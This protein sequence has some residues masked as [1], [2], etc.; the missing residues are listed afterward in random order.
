MLAGSDFSKA[1]ATFYGPLTDRH[2]SPSAAP[3]LAVIVSHL[4]NLS[5]QPSSL[6]TYKR[7]WKLFYDFFHTSFPG[8]KVI[9]PIS[10]PYLELFILFVRSYYAAST[11][12]TYISAI[13]YSHK[14]FSLLGPTK[15]FFIVQM[16]KGYGKLG[17]CIDGRLPITLPIPHEILYLASDLS[18]SP[19]ELCLFR[20]MFS[21]AFYAFL[22]VGEMAATNNDKS[23]LSI[24][25]IGNHVVSLKVTF[26]HYKHSYNQPP[27]SVIIQC[28]SS[29]CPVQFMLD[30]LKLRGN[31]RGPLSLSVGFRFID[32]FFAA[33]LPLL[34][35]VAVLTRHATKVIVFESELPLMRLRGK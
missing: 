26:L 10:A 8:V 2:S 13:S 28:Q 9:L 3:E 1:G 20:A 12:N 17:T 25:N 27:F 18:R 7:S 16:Y 33:C 15:V 5:L 6:P 21:L 31:S 30:Y 11:A 19:Y 32:S 4:I 14:L 35:S 24:D 34:L 22:H 29:F 23:L